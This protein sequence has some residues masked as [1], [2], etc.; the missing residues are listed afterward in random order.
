[1]CGQFGPAAQYATAQCG[2]L[3]NV[4]SSKPTD[5]VHPVVM[6]LMQGPRDK[7]AK[8]PLP[9][10]SRRNRCSAEVVGLVPRPDRLS[11]AH[12]SL[13]SIWARLRATHSTDRYKPPVGRIATIQIS[14]IALSAEIQASPGPLSID[15]L[16]THD[17]TDPRACDFWISQIDVLPDQPSRA[18]APRI[19]QPF[20]HS[21]VPSE[22]EIH[23][24][25]C[26]SHFRLTLLPFTRGISWDRR[27]SASVP[28]AGPITL[29]HAV[30]AIAWGRPCFCIFIVRGSNEF[31]TG[32]EFQHLLVVGIGNIHDAK[33][34]ASIAAL[35]RTV[36]TSCVWRLHS[37]PPIVLSVPQ[38]LGS[39]TAGYDPFPASC[40][41]H[42][43]TMTVDQLW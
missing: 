35:V 29:D 2:R 43:P 21:I 15:S 5:T 30:I 41:A 9:P 17:Q 26:R 27:V 3:Q 23:A 16:I 1:M 31:G 22:Q 39:R 32:G 14:R 12:R 13:R 20:S 34:I 10:I 40:Q 28:P 19:N 42:G 18:L 37:R 6:S 24:V 33:W 36:S 7:F 8:S 4:R 25:V 38:N 11:V